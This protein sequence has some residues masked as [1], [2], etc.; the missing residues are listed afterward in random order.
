MQ[1]R[2][3]K[4]SSEIILKLYLNHLPSHLLTQEKEKEIF[5]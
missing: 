3:V 1:L 5:C 4:V 2:E